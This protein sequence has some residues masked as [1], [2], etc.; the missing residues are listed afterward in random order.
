[1][2]IKN[3]NQNN[4][5]I[6]I[7]DSEELLVTDGQSALDLAA[8][9]IYENDCQNIIMPKSAVCEDFLKLSTGVEGEVVQKFVNYGCRVAIIG[10]YTGYT[11][12]PL[13]N[14]IY[15]C[16]NGSNIFFFD[17][18]SEAVRKLAGS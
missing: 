6:A 5:K 11:S 18:E 12:K 9:V 13:R 10:D 2:N 3:I 8:V 7:I 17:S 16:N 1:M 15:E 14:F 4:T